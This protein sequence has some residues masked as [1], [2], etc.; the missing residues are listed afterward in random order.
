MNTKNN[1]RPKLTPALV[2]CSDVMTN[3]IEEFYNISKDFIIYKLKAE[4]E[5]ILHSYSE[6]P[7]VCDGGKKGCLSDLFWWAEDITDD[8][9]S[10]F[11]AYEWGAFIISINTIMNEIEAGHTSISEVWSDIQNLKI[12]KDKYLRFA[13]WK[14]TPKPIDLSIN[15]FQ[16]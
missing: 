11:S 2:V 7:D 3:I 10:M 9:T 5:D 14:Q 8:T 13:G 15:N 4:G 1:H 6:D 16:F 12:D